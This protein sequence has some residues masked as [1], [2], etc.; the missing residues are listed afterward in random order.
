MNNSLGNNSAFT[1][2]QMQLFDGMSSMGNNNNMNQLMA[3][4]CAIL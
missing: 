3:M 4:A 2:N 1:A